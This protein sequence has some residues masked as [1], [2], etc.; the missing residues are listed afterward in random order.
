[1]AKSKFSPA[2]FEVIR[3]KQDPVDGGKLPV[4]K[5]WK[6]GSQTS[7]DDAEG[8][9]EDSASST[10][11]EE[12]AAEAPAA[13]PASDRTVLSQ[14]SVPTDARPRYVAGSPMLQEDRDPP[15]AVR[16]GQGRI[17]LSLNPVMATVVAGTL[18]VTLFAF[19]ELGH[20]SGYKSAK[21]A[22]VA[23]A[24]TDEVDRLVSG[25]PK[26]DV[27]RATPAQPRPRANREREASPPTRVVV[28]PTES[29]TKNAIPPAPAVVKPGTARHVLLETFKATDRESAEF[30]RKWLATNKKMETNV[31]TR[32]DHGIVLVSAETFDYS[33]PGDEQKAKLYCETIKT[34][35]KTIGKE[36]ARAGLKNYLFSSPQVR[37]ER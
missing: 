10:L 22:P 1:M 28:T 13:D 2:L 8:T 11:S 37:A 16:M 31:E 21:N 27:L 12:I 23:A 14:P 3:T 35:G 6:R 32:G 17:A 25:S 7:S 5:W 15:P 33:K 34:L 19:Y 30:A 26:P 4:P 9:Q 24:G 20:H 29:G 36:M 18:L